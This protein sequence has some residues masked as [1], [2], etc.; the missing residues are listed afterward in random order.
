MK[1][2]KLLTTLLALTL[3]SPL[4]MA[5]QATIEDVSGQ[6][7]SDVTSQCANF[8]NSSLMV[9]VKL[10]DGEPAELLQNIHVVIESKGQFY[11]F[12]TVGGAKWIPISIKG[13]MT[14]PA[15]K[16][17]FNLL[18]G[19]GLNSREMSRQ[20][21]LYEHYTVG[22]KVYVGV[23]AN[24]TA[25]FLEGSVKEAFVVKSLVPENF[26]ATRKQP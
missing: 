7:D 14:S 21:P 24:D 1:N 26:L 11:Q 5:Y 18:P 23:R 6:C 20:T 12:Q 4:T 16:A 22:T 9:T 10:D 8:G 13:L 2:F 25:G 17:S 3:L 15:L 19:M